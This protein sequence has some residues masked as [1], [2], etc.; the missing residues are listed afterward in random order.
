[1]KVTIYLEYFIIRIIFSKQK[2][3]RCEL[4]DVT[5][6]KIMIASV[7]SSIS[8]NI[9]VDFIRSVTI[10]NIFH[11]AGLHFFM[12]KKCIIWEY[13]SNCLGLSNV[14]CSIGRRTLVSSFLLIIGLFFH[15]VHTSNPK[16]KYKKS[17]RIIDTPHFNLGM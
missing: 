9:I 1:M 3:V 15:L 17:D 4:G 2:F 16:H 8:Q 5:N 12:L 14:P 13:I 7:I 10:F 6:I 11:Y